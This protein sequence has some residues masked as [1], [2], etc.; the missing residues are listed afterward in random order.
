MSPA[1]MKSFIAWIYN[2][3]NVLMDFDGLTAAL[4]FKYCLMLLY[5]LN[6]VKRCSIFRY[7]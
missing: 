1:V 2:E 5:F 7:C 4:I 6:I 3:S